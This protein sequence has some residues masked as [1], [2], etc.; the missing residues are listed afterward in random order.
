MNRLTHKG[1]VSQNQLFTTLGTSV[2][3]M[4]VADGSERGVNILLSDTIGFIRDLPPELIEAFA[5][6]LED[7][8]ESDLLLHVVDANDPRIAEKIAIVQ[9]TLEHIE[10]HQ[11]RILVFNKCDQ[12]GEEAR[13]KLL[14]IYPPNNTCV[15]VSAYSGEGIDS[16]K[17]MILKHTLANPTLV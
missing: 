16:L 7:S 9:D 8:V 2:G 3:S 10:A 1:V 11:G 6:T 14:E 17:Q 15:W 4:Y 13:T 12:L 5:S